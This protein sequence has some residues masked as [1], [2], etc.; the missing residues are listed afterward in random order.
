[1]NP[2]TDKFRLHVVDALRGFALVS[3][4]LLHNIEH[5]DFYYLPPTLPAWMVSL[6][7]V[8]WETLFFLFGGKS[9]GI[10]ALLFGLT[11]FIQLNS[12]MKR[13]EDFRARFAWRL[14]LLFCFGIIN[15]MFYQGD[16]LMLYAFIG[17]FLIPIAKFRN[18]ALLCIAVVLLL[19][20]LQWIAM[21][22]ALQHPDLKLS[23]P[24]SWSYFGKMEPYITGSSF[25]NTVKG[26]LLNGKLAVIY[27]SWENGRF[28][29]ILALFI[30]GTLAG[31][32]Q[33]F[34]ST[35]A[36]K[37]FWKKTLIWAIAAFLLLYN[38]EKRTGSFISNE[39]I[40]RP[41]NTL[42]SSWTHVSFMTVLIAG[43]YLLFHLKMFNKALNIF[44]PIGRMSLSNYILQSILGSSIYYGF[45]LGLY[46]YTGA[47]YSLLIGIA[48]AILLGCLSTWWAKNHQRGPLE[49]IWNK[50]TWIKSRPAS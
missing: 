28:F 26:N 7:K 14:V 35:T 16:I 41:F 37:S 23:D 39:A 5:F 42:I 11:F 24:Q 43:F 9:Y 3:I 8:I 6:D 45:G 31:R 48:L 1:M 38:V 13:G 27:W 17:F 10:F 19:Q 44:S 18:K 36:N 12:R 34:A 49:E 46:R 29:H 33:L 4:M 15:S 25:L 32:K 21:F 40:L 50:A 30:L 22:Q 2:T 47:T 20:P